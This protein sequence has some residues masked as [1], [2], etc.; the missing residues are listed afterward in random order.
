MYNKTVSD[1]TIDLN[2]LQREVEKLL[3]FLNDRQTGHMS[4]HKFMKERLENIH[5]F[6]SR[7]LGK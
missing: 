6:T 1:Q 2:D 5:K 3:A 7:A 4:W